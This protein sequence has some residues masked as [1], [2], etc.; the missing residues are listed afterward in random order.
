MAALD[1]NHEGARARRTAANEDP[2]SIRVDEAAAAH[3]EKH[4]VE[5]L[6]EERATTL[7]RRPLWPLYRTILYP[8]LKHRQAVA[9]ADYIA[10]MDGMEA[11]TAVSDLLA[12]D[13]A[14]SGLEKLPA[15]GRILIAS[16]H[17]TGIADGVAMFDALKAKR[18]DLTFFANRDAIRVVPR[19]ADLMIPVEW[20]IEKRTRARS[21]ETLVAAREAFSAERCVILFPSGRLA[22]MD[23]NKELVEQEWMNSVAIFARKYD[24]AILPVNIRAR[25]SWIYYWFRNLSQELKDITL[26]REL[27][28]KK[29]QRFD[30]AFGD[31]IPP[32]DLRGDHNDVTEALRRHALEDVREGRPW[33]PLE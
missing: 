28:N 22:Y 11:L 29:G 21:R 19:F 2:P 10:D 20:A 9:M 24:C 26:F 16:T 1:E 30:I 3:A 15:S 8:V 13:V 17:P 27:L 32:D 12:L 6:I 5:Q 18:P 23:D 31:V 4:I 7:V 33:R 14:V 25:N